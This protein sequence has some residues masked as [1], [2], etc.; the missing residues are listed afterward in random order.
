MKVYDDDEDVGCGVKYFCHG[1]CHVPNKKIDG[2]IG[3][4]C[5]LQ[6]GNVCPIFTGKCETCKCALGCNY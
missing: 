4:I 2:D 3:P 6:K 1:K 5:A